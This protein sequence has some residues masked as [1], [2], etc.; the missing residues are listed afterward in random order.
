MATAAGGRLYLLEYIVDTIDVG[1]FVV[2]PQLRIVLWNKFMAHHS[3]VPR[4]TAVGATLFDLFPYLPQNW[5]AK[6]FERVFLLKNSSFTS[7][8]QRP[9]LFSFPHNRPITGGID[10]MQQNATLM[11]VTG[12]D[13][14]VK[15]VCVCIFDVTDTAILQRKLRFAI[16]DLKG[17]RSEQQRLIGEL[18][19]AQDQL[20]QS[21]KLV[22]I[23]QLAAGVAHEINNPV[24]FV[25][26]NIGSLEKYISGI[27]ELLS[28]LDRNEEHLPPDVKAEIT[29][30]KKMIDYQYMLGDMND[31]IRESKDGVERIRRIVNDLRDFSR[32]GES[33]WQW[34]NVHEC[35]D[36]TLNVA[37]N[38][39]KY[40][41]EVIKD[42]GDLPDIECMP[43][44]LNQV[45]LNLLVNA[46]HAISDRGTIRIVTNKEGDGVKI[47]ISDTGCGMT[48]EVTRRI[49]DPF[50]TTKPVGKGTGLG[51]SVS[52]GII[53]RH[54]GTIEVASEPG[55]GSCFVLWLPI[56]QPK[57][58]IVT[59]RTEV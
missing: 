42:Y 7:W 35:I 36:S 43:F 38:E 24:G 59:R 54:R 46:A 15:L 4:Q 3:G 6:K 17:E 12:A 31:L 37:W 57:E 55:K 44:Q 10:F 58:S 2:D 18:A 27:M 56:E 23:G 11:P 52:Q 22:A 13:G 28:C 30:I 40:K 48:P 39:V 1:V 26:S 21:E 5:L 14:D 20:V 29:S 41:A 32:V 45:F 25:R 49:F 34:A 19:E 53:N 8:E 50:F 33:E 47:A 16:E 51:L 9:Y